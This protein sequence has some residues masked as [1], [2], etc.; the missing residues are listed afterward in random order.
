MNR[1]TVLVAT[2]AWLG[3]ALLLTQL[4]WFGRQRLVDRLAPYTVAGRSMSAPS[5]LPWR[6][7]L[8]P[9]TASF[10][11]RLAQLLGGAESA[12]ARL[13]RVHATTDA[14]T[15][16][17]RQVAA[18]VVSVC[19]GGMIAT[20]LASGSVFTILIVAGCALASFLAIE[21]Q[22]SKRAAAWQRSVLAELPVIAEQLGMLLASGYSLGTSLSRIGD[23]GHGACAADLRRVTARI[24]QGLSELAALQEWAATVA[25]PAVDR[26]VGVLA[27]NRETT[28]LGRLIGEEARA[29][30]RDAH[31]RLIEQLERRSQQ[32]WIPVTIAAL[33]PGVILLAIPFTE[34]LRLFTAP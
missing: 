2:A 31:R 13:Q 25:V 3:L 34:A 18:S 22:L 16:R 15:F 27:L 6:Q 5:T 8:L 28:E 30:R 14:T 1:V 29:Q 21:R 10:G 26:L 4:R 20:L 24:R 33:V 32:V 23:R 12:G 7:A 17:V 9:A 11:E 19:V